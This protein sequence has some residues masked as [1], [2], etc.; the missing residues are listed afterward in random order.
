M[1]TVVKSTVPRHKC[2]V[3]GGPPSHHLAAIAATIKHHLRANYP[4]LYLNT[5]T[6]VAG[7]RSYLA[8]TDVDVAYEVAKASLILSSDRSHLVD[9][10]FVPDRMLAALEDSIC[11]AVNDGYEGLWASGDMS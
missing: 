8:A 7:L 11:Q 3:Y 10:V 4:G 9:G 6:M 1:S 2:Q 5:P